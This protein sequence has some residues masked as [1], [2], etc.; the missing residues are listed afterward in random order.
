M[1]VKLMTDALACHSQG[2]RNGALIA[3]KRIQRQFPGFAV[4]WINASALLNEMGRF[5]ESLPMALK[6]TELDPENPIAHCELAWGHKKLGHPKEAGASYSKALEYDPEHPKALVDLADIYASNGYFSLALEL[7]DRAIRACP[8]HSVVWVCRGNNKIR[9]MDFAGAEADYRQA[10]EL[11]SNNANAHIQL[12]H[13]LLLRGRL[14][15]AWP[16]L[17]ASQS[18]GL[19][20]NSRNDF[21]KP[22]WKGEELNGHT[23]LVY[24]THHGTGGVGDVIQFARYFPY[25][26]QK[27]GCCIQLL[28]YKSLKRLLAGIPAIDGIFG[29]GEPLP[30]F[31]EAVPI[32]ELASLLKIDFSNLPPPTRLVP[33]LAPTPEIASAGFKVGLAWAGSRS[34][35]KDLFRSISPRF[36]DDLADMQGIAWYGLQVPPEDDPPRLPGFTDLSPHISDFM[37]TATL[38]KQLDLFVTVDT[39][40]A[41]MAGSMGLPTL[42]LLPYLAEWRWGQSSDSTPWYPT[43]TLLRQPAHGDWK[44]VIVMLKERIKLLAGG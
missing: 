31:D 16:H 12:A 28:T 8:A 23:L 10:L 17:D 36:L 1:L 19:G 41:H 24:S 40:V 43:M 27:Y 20:W 37:D 29:E 44:S 18:L 7:N 3:Y 26:Q 14:L 2:N 42:L 13:A 30:D 39:S 4:A 9:A 22:H 32:V 5:E 6:G 21:G 33:Q 35:S 34:N 38:A 25:M 15:E 11:D